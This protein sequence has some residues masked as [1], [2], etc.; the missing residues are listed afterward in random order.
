VQVLKPFLKEL[1]S[2]IATKAEDASEKIH[3]LIKEYNQTGHVPYKEKDRLYAQFKE[4]TDQLKKEL[5]ISVNRKRLDDF[6]NNLK[7]VVSNGENALYNERNKLFRA[8]E[9]MKQELQTYENNLGFLS[10]ASKKGNSLISNF[11]QKTE[12]LKEEMQLLKE[13]IKEIDRQQKEENDNE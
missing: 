7:N 8:Y 3:Q 13:K 10:A 5:N 12:K 1:K 9:R 6:K 2:F 4:V 11:T